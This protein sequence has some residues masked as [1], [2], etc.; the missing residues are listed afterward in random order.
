LTEVAELFEGEIQDEQPICWNCSLPIR[1]PARYCHHCGAIQADELHE[2]SEKKT[3]RIWLASL[4]FAFQLI[5]CLVLQFSDIGD[6][7][8]PALIFDGIF[9]AL[10][11]GFAALGWEAIKPSLSFKGFSFLRAGFYMMLAAGFSIIVQYMMDWL[12]YTLF[13]RDIIYYRAF[14]ET[15]SPLLL[16]L[17]F[18]AVQ[19]AIF[20][21]LGFRGIMQGT[22]NKVLDIPQSLSLT[23]FAFAFIHLSLLSIVWLIP[24]AFM[25]G[26]IRS[27]ENSIWYGVLVHFVFN[28]IAVFH[29]LPEFYNVL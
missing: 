4:F 1:Q 7:F 19:P 10:T 5:L 11:I 9:I 18:I 8:V 28:A 23:A 12:N 29:D 2:P 25:L 17:V 22:L 14:L 3:R 27:R 15:G 13:E 16:M 21:E 20:E 6:G 26:Y 24:F